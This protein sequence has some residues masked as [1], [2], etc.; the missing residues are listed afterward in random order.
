MVQLL[1]RGVGTKLSRQITVDADTVDPEVR[2]SS[3][4][5]DFG[6]N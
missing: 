6:T 2:A 3:E 1:R 5:I 4:L